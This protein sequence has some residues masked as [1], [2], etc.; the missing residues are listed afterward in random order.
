MPFI[1]FI[2][3]APSLPLSERTIREAL[4]RVDPAVPA[5]EVRTLR[6][7]L[8]LRTERMRFVAV[9]TS[10]FGVVGLVFAVTGTYGVIRHI[11]NQKLREYALR[12]ALGASPQR[13]RVDL[14]G[15]SAALIAAGLVVGGIL[16]SYSGAAL[17][18][19]MGRTPRALIPVAACLATVLIA[20]PALIAVYC[21]ARD[22]TTR[23]PASLLKES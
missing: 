7:M 3:D 20:V 15:E 21:V 5:D 22:V 12:S 23:N 4:R 8:L 1:R 6:D 19:V 16:A 2:I 13:L 17:T 11:T 18:G 10:A 14:I 9:L